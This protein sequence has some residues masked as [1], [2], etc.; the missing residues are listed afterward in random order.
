MFQ[1][2]CNRYRGLPVFERARWVLAFIFDVE[3]GEAEQHTKLVGWEERCPTLSD[4]WIL[5]WIMQREKL[6]VSP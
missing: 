1:Q 6:A 2:S 4:R 3:I 5:G